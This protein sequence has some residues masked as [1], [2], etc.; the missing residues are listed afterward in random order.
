M[1]G[2]GNTYRIVVRNPERKKETTLETRHEW[3]MILTS[4]I[5]NVKM[6]NGC[7]WFRIGS[8]DGFLQIALILHIP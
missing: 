4:E 1:G 6:C 3:K 8:T 7:S 2:M 5:T